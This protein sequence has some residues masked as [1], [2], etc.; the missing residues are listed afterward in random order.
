MILKQTQTFLKKKIQ[1]IS[2]PLH[3]RTK[4][5][6]LSSA[7]RAPVLPPL[8]PFL[9]GSLRV[10]PANAQDAPRSRTSALAMTCAQH[11]TSLPN[12]PP[13]TS[14]DSTSGW[15]PQSRRQAPSRPRTS[16]F[17]LNGVLC[18]LAWNTYTILWL[19]LATSHIRLWTPRTEPEPHA[20]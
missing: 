17:L 9:V 19:F 1:M 5:K 11:V 14:A 20:L 10:R 13:S 2:L 7:F 12:S 16:H 3:C 6:F 15:R 4:P 8:L 18:C